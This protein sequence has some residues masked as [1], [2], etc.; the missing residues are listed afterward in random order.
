MTMSPGLRKTLLSLSGASALTLAGVMV[1]ELEGVRY[2]AYYD[3]AGVLTVCYGHTGKDIIPG[4]RYSEAEC[5][6]L[7]NKDLLP[8]SRAVERAVTV[9]TDEYQKAALISFSY[10]VGITAFQKSSVLRYLNTG[11]EG[12]ACEA[13]K[14][15]IRAGGRKWQGLMNRREVEYE[16]CRWHR[17]RA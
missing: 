4:K 17:R 12:K 7:L 14:Q 13:L 2:T 10:N 15:W 8:F 9:P 16:V 5:E 6:K 3:V 11:E 1:P